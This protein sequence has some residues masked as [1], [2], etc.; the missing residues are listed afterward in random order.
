MLTF[1]VPTTGTYT[2]SVGGGTYRY[3]AGVLVGLTW[4]VRLGMPGAELPADPVPFSDA[5]LA[6]LLDSGI[7]ANGLIY[8]YFPDGAIASAALIDTANDQDF[9][10][11]LWLGQFGTETLSLAAVTDEI[12]VNAVQAA[13]PGDAWGEGVYVCD[14][15]NRYDCGELPEGRYTVG[16]TIRFASAPAEP[17]VVNVNAFGGAGADIEIG[18]DQLVAH[19]GSSWQRVTLPIWRKGTGPVGLAV[20][21]ISD[22][23]PSVVDPVA[24]TLQISR[25][26]VTQG[27]AFGFADGDSDDWTWSGIAHASPSFGPQP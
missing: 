11:H 9:D 10:T 12:I 5:Q 15:S 2:D 3:T 4:A 7:A 8:N 22:A 27:N 25:L 13:L 14:W 18:P 26:M 23:N 21:T 19:A 17:V 20:T 1:T 16:A 24:V 6:Y